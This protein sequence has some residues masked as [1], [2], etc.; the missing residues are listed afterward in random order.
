MSTAKPETTIASLEA[1]DIRAGTVLRAEPF[2]E[3][4]P[5]AI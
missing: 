2:P 1:L 4:R 5:P 3:A